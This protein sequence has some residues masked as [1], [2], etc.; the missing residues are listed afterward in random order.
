MTVTWTD[1]AE[2]EPERL[3]L[4][5]WGLVILRGI[6]FILVLIIG[7][8]LHEII[9][10]IERPFAGQT[11][12]VSPKI[13]Q[14]VCRIGLVFLGIKM[15]VHGEIMEH[16]GAVVANHSSWLDI[17]VLNARKRIYF[18]AKSEVKGWAG[19]GWLARAT[20]TVFINRDRREAKKHTDVLKER[21]GYGHRLLF[22]PEGTSTDN[23]R[24]LPFKTTLFAP[25]LTEDIRENAHIQPVSVV[26]HAP[27]GKDPRFYG[28]WGDMEF[29]SHILQVLGSRKKGSVDVICHP[30]IRMADHSDRKKLALELETQVRAGYDQ[31]TALER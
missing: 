17:F 29:A 9:R 6:P 3:T 7:L 28:W 14:V 19:I 20:G 2:P 18:V 13:T 22:F 31:Y 15:R 4:L 25:F 5:G 1:E 12:P 30:A 16:P 10:V 11:R 27:V 8:A 21:L 26:Y 23:K 24:V